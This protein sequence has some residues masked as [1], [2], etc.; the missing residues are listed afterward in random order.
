[1]IWKKDN[2]LVTAVPDVF[3]FPSHKKKEPPNGRWASYS[4]MSYN[5]YL[6][7]TRFSGDFS[8][9]SEATAMKRVRAASCVHPSS[10]AA[11]YRDHGAMGGTE[12]E[13]ASVGSMPQKS[14]TT[15]KAAFFTFSH[16]SQVWV[17][18]DSSPSTQ[19]TAMTR[20]SATSCVYGPSWV[21]V[22]TDEE[23]VE[24]SE[25]VTARVVNKRQKDLPRL[26]KQI[27]LCFFASATTLL[28]R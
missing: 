27:F 28:H 7:T 2:P 21:V 26:S 10:D 22:D 6:P 24:G 18:H 14:P 11:A 12:A 9:Q 19:A 25:I 17:T 4:Y 16:M 23:A 8:A 3:F 1:M 15:S 5:M 20:A 13:A